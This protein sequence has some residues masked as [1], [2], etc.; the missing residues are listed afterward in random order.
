MLVK[1]LTQDEVDE[2]L[3][4]FRQRSQAVRESV[5]D[6]VINSGACISLDDAYNMDMQDFYALRKQLVDLIEIK[7]KAKH[8][9]S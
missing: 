6:L 1:A 4:N 7:T 9:K 8:N 3:D 5:F 2:I